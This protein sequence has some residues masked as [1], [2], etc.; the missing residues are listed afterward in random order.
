MSTRIALLSLVVGL[1]PAAG[2]AP[3]VAADAVRVCAT[4]PDL[5]DLAKQVGGDVVRVTVFTK[6]PQDPHFLDARPSFIRALSRADVFLLAGMDLEIGWAPALLRSARN[7]G[8]QAGAPGYLD[9]S[10]GVKPLFPDGRRLD[11]S[12]GDVH[13]MGNPH[14]LLDPLNGLH[15]ARRIATKLEALH[16]AERDRLERRFSEFRGRL[17]VALL[18]AEL[19]ESYSVGDLKKLLTIYAHPSGGMAKL[20]EV[21]EAEKK[22]TLLGGWV[23]LMR[24]HAGAA[25]VADHNLWPYFAGRFGVDVVDFLEPKPGISPTT[26]HLAGLVKTMR[27]RKIEVIL[28]APYFDS[29]HAEF[30]S[31]HT[32]AVVAPMAHQVGARKGADDYIAMIDYNVRTLAAALRKASAKPSD[33]G[34]SG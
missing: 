15:V 25:V 3:V 13:P 4:I 10:V 19:V 8:V 32:G 34:D 11:R 28:A 17:I 14:Y 5:G 30:V 26:R 27:A 7:A 18:G 1:T 2:T 9:A 22:T 21:L 20:L 12:M 23:K 29:R 16:P 24:P 31:R 6:G 33:G